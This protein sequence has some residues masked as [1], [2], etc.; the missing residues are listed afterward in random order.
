MSMSRSLLS[1]SLLA[2]AAAVASPVRAAALALDAPRCNGAREPL[3]LRDAA[4]RFSWALTGD[5]PASRPACAEVR[6]ED[7]SGRETWRGRTAG[8]LFACVYAGPALRPGEPYR[9][10]ARL[11]RE[12]GVAATAWCAPQRFVVGLQTPSDWEGAQWVGEDAFP[13]AWADV[14]YQVRFTLVKDAFGLFFRARDKHVGYMWQVNTRLDPAGLLR[15]HV[16]LPD[17]GMRLLP[18]VRLTPL[19][20]KGLD[21]TKEHVLRVTARGASIRTF[22]DGV[23]VDER[24]DTTFVAGTV[25]IRCS[26]GEEAFVSEVS[27]KD[28]SGATLLFDRFRGHIM[29]AFRKP[30]LDGDRVHL[31]GTELLHPGILPKNAPRVRK[32]FR[33]RGR[34]VKHAFASACGW[35]FYELWINGRKADPTRVLAPGMTDPARA[36]LFDTYDVAPLLKSGVANTVGFWLAPGYSDDFS[37]YA[38]HWL[39]PRRGILHLAIVY[40]D[41]TRDVVVTDGSWETTQASEVVRASIYHGETVDATR[42]DA[43]WCTPAGTRDGWRPAHVWPANEAGPL[44][45]NDAPPVRMFDPRR[46]VSVAEIRPG[47]FVADFG[48]NR[49]GFVQVRAKGPRGTRIRVRTSELLGADGGIDPWTNGIAESTDEFVLAGTGAVEELVP[50]FTYHGFQFIEITG[51]PGRPTADDLVGWAVSA[52]V[53]RTGSFVC[54]NEGLNKYVNAADWSMRSN[55]VSYPTD[56]CMRGER[57]PCQMDSQAYEDAALQW[58]EMSRY[59]AKWLDD[60]AGGRGNPDWT[61]D[62]VVLPWR[63]YWATGDDRVLAAHYDDM[64]AQVDADVRKWPGLVCREGFGDWCAP[65]DG[66]WKGYFN[67]VEIVNSA[68][69]C[70]MCRVVAAS[71]E[72]LGKTSDIAAYRGLHAR[73]KSAFQAKFF[74]S[75]TKTYGDGSQTTSTLPLAFGIVPVAE[76]ESVARALVRTI[77]DVDGGRVNAGIFGMRYLG[78]VLCDAGAGDLYVHL[79]T[80]PEFPGFGYMFAHGATTL[81]EQWTFKGGMNTHNHAMFSGSLHSLLTGLAGIRAVSPGYAEIEVRPIFPQALGRL[82]AHR[83][84]PRGRVAVSWRREDGHVTLEVETPPLTSATLRLP[85]GT[86]RRLVAGPVTVTVDAGLLGHMTKPFNVE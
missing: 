52:D 42:A 18:P 6:V 82:A 16:F 28:A 71:A 32:T 80:Q 85:D 27:V 44:R 51:W 7:G 12:D 46:P 86:S 60:I 5:E 63:L 39:A 77:R 43:A 23:K 73:A 17:G 8:D 64:K 31:K 21:W 20:P 58:F 9:W 29:P 68:L 74:H 26:A 72:V 70:E 1:I 4:P 47:V 45:A 35:G 84:T 69:F 67:D 37:R 30:P 76:R 53:E 14:D 48:Q 81:W 2:V 41:G 22:L 3:G 55:F 15:P 66:T 59:Y 19:F 34:P 65:N 10:Q 40:D 54:D 36:S 50:R 62:S 25:G 75:E 79:M 57:T 83:D 33:L 13:V 11:L 61:G 49:A 38:W 78:D 56:C 24:T